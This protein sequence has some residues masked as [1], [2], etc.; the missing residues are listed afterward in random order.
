V[1]GDITPNESTTYQVRLSGY[2]LIS[3]VARA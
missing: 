2:P 1:R 3:V